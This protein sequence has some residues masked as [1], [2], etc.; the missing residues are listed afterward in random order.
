M[1]VASDEL[2]IHNIEGLRHGGLRGSPLPTW[3]PVGQ[4][5]VIFI[6]TGVSE[7]GAEDLPL[8]FE[9]PWPGEC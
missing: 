8:L 3:Q 6:S 9:S 2:L 7:S 5:A 4:V 1:T